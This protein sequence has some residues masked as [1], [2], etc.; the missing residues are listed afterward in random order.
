M[1]KSGRPQRGRGR[2]SAFSRWLWR[3]VTFVLLLL[4][5]SAGLLGAARRFPLESLIFSTIGV[6]AVV[7]V[8]LYVGEL[9]V[10]GWIIDF[11]D[12]IAMPRMHVKPSP[13]EYEPCGEMIVVRLRDNVGT[14]LQCQSVQKQLKALQ[15]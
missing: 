15:G 5:V 11:L 14:V 8:V 7:G 9:V 1:K 6:L 10:L 3:F 12:W 4:V 13:L 2:F